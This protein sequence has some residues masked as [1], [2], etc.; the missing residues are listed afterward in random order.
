MVDLHD[1][2]S[3]KRAGRYNSDDIRS[4]VLFRMSLLTTVTDRTGQIFFQRRFGISLR[5]YRTIGVVGYAQPISVTELADEC[6]LDKGQ[7]SRIVLKLVE[8]GYLKRT[9]ETGKRTDRG[10]MLRLTPKGTELLRKGVK[11]GRE[12]NAEALNV[13]SRK[14]IDE[15][16]DYLDRLLVIAERRYVEAER[17]PSLLYIDASAGNES[18]KHNDDFH[19]NPT[20][21]VR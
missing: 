13:L 20:S 21:R 1:R 11:Y 5:E 2:K 3:A 16:S 15:F 17:N 9:D 8:S 6:F 19:R 7:M 14:E 18:Q 10:G 12:L 4:L